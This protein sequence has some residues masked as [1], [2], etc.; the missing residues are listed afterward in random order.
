MAAGHWHLRPI[1]E[2]DAAFLFAT[3]TDPGMIRA[4]TAPPPG[5]QAT[6]SDWIERAVAAAA[7]GTS[8]TWVVVDRAGHGP[9]ARGDDGEPVGLSV[10]QEIDRVNAIAEAGYFV[11]EPFRGSRIATTCLVAVTE[12]AFDTLALERV[13]LFH[14]T[15]NPAS[16]RVASGA[17][18]VA[19]GI[20][21]S[22]RRRFD[23]EWV[24]QEVHARL[25]GDSWDAGR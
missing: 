16:C 24:D 19:E 13:Q 14:D 9:D 6:A 2:H 11:T 25:R 17:G 7:A 8:L 5:D 4:R 20:L 1:G 18:F 23:G 3:L 21:R 15:D 22:S 12:W 10:L